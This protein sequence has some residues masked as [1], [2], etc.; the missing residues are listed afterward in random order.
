MVLSIEPFSQTPPPQFWGA[1]LSPP[2][3]PPPPAVESPTSQIPKFDG[4]NTYHC[5]DKGV[6]LAGRW[7]GGGDWQVDSHWQRLP[8][9]PFWGGG[10]RGGDSPRALLERRW[11]GG[12]GSR[13]GREGV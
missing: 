4:N 7:G 1:L 2:P 8:T 5:S 3:P 10:V 6:A 11:E 13:G 9:A 12:R